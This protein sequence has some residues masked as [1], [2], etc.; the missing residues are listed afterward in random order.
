MATTEAGNASVF[1]PHF[2]R[3]FNNHRPVDWSVL[4][5]IKK[6]EVMDKLDHPISWNDIKKST[7]KLANDKSP[8]LNGVPPNVF[9]SL[10]DANITWLLI[11][12]NQFW[13]SQ[14]EFDECH[15]FQVVPVHQKG[16]TTNPNKWRG[17]TLMDI[18]KKIHISITCVR[19]FKIIRKHGVKFQFGS[20]PGVGCQDGKFTINKLLHLRHNHNLQK[21]V[22]FT[23]LV[24]AF[25]TSNYTLL[26]AILGKYGA[27][28]RLFSEIKRTYNKSI[29]KLIIGK[30]DTS[31]DLKVGFNQGDST[32]PL[33]FLF[34]IMAFAETLED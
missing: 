15:E 12:Y 11:F 22:A 28:P 30:V 26:I 13:H 27:H 34:L 16:D 18:G 19:L 4:Y 1:G 10:D 32:S 9:K 33:L 8:E 31:I 3:I 7:T 20:T 6:R 21:W 23:D 29:V 14:A 25:D 2:H 17:V 5:K 24:K